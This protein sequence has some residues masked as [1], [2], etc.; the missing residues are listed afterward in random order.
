MLKKVEEKKV[1]NQPKE[2]NRKL[3]AFSY[4]TVSKQE[5]GFFLRSVACSSPNSFISKIILHEIPVPHH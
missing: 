1:K 5:F 3:S 4:L 2:Q